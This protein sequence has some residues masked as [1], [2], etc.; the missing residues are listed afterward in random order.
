MCGAGG[1]GLPPT[2]LTEILRN[3]LNRKKEFW[4][5]FTPVHKLLLMEIVTFVFR[6]DLCK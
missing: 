6:N 5:N 4:G 2:L 3:F 1:Y